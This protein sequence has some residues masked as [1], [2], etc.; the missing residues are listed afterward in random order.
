MNTLWCTHFTFIFISATKSVQ[1][2]RFPVL[3]CVKSNEKDPRYCISVNVIALYLYI[4]QLQST[5]PRHRL[6][7]GLS[8]PFIT[9]LRIIIEGCLENGRESCSSGV[10]G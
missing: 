5:A 6:P 9:D 4:I 3:P 2:P 8:Q 10:T 7:P 1:D